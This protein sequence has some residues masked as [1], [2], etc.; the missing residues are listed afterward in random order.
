MSLRRLSLAAAA[1]SH[2]PGPWLVKRPIGIIGHEKEGDRLIVSE[3]TKEHVAEVFQYRNHNHKDEATALANARLIAASPCMLTAL[4]ECVT[5][6]EA[7]R[8]AQSTGERWP[9]PNHIFHARAA[10]A[11]AK[12]C[13]GQDPAGA[14]ASKGVPNAT[15]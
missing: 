11:K 10:I 8:G 12:A 6:Y 15:G 4:E 3:E 5:V 7:H 1:A 2:T 14:A 9:D 13:G